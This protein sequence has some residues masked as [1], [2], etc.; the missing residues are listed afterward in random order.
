MHQAKVFNKMFDTIKS[1]NSANE[2]TQNIKFQK[3]QNIAILSLQNFTTSLINNVCRE[4]K[5]SCQRCS[6]AQQTNDN[7]KFQLH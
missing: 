6:G 5:N 1:N 7:A 4:V 3:Q 2:T